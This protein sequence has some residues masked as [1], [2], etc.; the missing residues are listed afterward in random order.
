MAVPK[1]RALILP[2]LHGEMESAQ[3][4]KGCSPVTERL[5]CA[6]KIASSIPGISRQ[7][8]RRPKPWRVDANHCRRYGTKA[9]SHVPN[10]T[11]CYQSLGTDQKYVPL[12]HSPSVRL[13]IMA[14]SF[15][16]WLS[17]GSQPA[18]Y[19]LFQDRGTPKPAKGVQPSPPCLRKMKMLVRRPR[20]R[21]P[22]GASSQSLKR[23]R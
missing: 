9:T 2:R 4:G 17:R 19:V 3:G 18:I 21:K 1:Q 7:G 6:Q 15:L 23:K 10:E 13:G 5:L 14:R 22:E 8:C 11:H 20:R 12:S 16:A